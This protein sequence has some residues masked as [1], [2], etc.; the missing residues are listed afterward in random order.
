[1]TTQQKMKW[2]T[3]ITIKDE[4]L[5][6]WERYY[7]EDMLIREQA[8]WLDNEFGSGN[9]TIIPTDDLPVN[10]DPATYTIENGQLVPAS[11]DVMVLREQARTAKRATVLRSQRDKALTATD[12][13]MIPDFPISEQQREQYRTYRQYLRDLPESDGFPDVPVMDFEEFIDG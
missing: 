13:Y 2:I 1:M 9:W 8:E 5:N 4:I 7:C 6:T 12:K 3:V 11:A 10:F